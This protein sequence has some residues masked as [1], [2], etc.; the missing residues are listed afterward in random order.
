MALTIYNRLVLK[1][2]TVF[3]LLMDLDETE[4]VNNPLDRVTKLQALVIKTN[5]M[6]KL[7]WMVPLLIDLYESGRL[8]IESCSHRALSGAPKVNK[9]LCD[10]LLVKQDIQEYV[11]RWSAEQKF[12][13]V[14]LDTM[15][16]S[17]VDV[18]TFRKHCGY[19]W[20]TS[21]SR[22]WNWKAGW[23]PSTEHLPS[24]F[25][26]VIY[27]PNF[28]EHL[29]SALTSRKTKP[30][31]IMEGAP[32]ME[33]L[34]DIVDCLEDENKSPET[35]TEPE[36]VLEGEHFVDDDTQDA[37]QR[38]AEEQGRRRLC[39]WGLKRIM[40]DLI[41]VSVCALEIC[42]LLFRHCPCVLL[43]DL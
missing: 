22:N 1:A 3:R 6:E 27:N 13:G 31:D 36:E 14:A 17:T 7:E 41:V 34:Q 30:E 38:R 28:D 26:M 37:F 42:F 21:S 15:R 19:A 40:R 5:T 25:E 18:E 8:S 24:I 32:F 20:V 23:K 11:L 33:L 4:G 12:P 9:G 2:P 39:R 10:V 35:K 29:L 16:Q 43:A